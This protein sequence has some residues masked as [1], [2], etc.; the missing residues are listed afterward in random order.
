MIS[1]ACIRGKNSKAVMKCHATSESWTSGRIH[2][3]SYGFDVSGNLK[4]TM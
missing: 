3:E 4:L 2:A 1:D